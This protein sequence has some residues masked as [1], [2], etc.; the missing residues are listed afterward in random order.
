[1]IFNTF[2]SI[3][4]CKHLTDLTDFRRNVSD[5]IRSNVLRENKSWVLLKI[6]HEE[7]MMRD[8]PLKCLFLSCPADQCVDKAKVEESEQKAAE[9]SKKV[10]HS[11]PQRP[12]R[13]ARP[14]IGKVFSFRRA[15]RQAIDFPCPDQYLG[16]TLHDPY[17]HYKNQCRCSDVY[18]FEHTAGTELSY[19]AAL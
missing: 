9:Y 19:V 7:L 10:R 14:P 6:P 15:P 3:Q 1:M 17:Q 12:P 4:S 18:L 11:S 2:L 8:A 5:P 16:V 13:L